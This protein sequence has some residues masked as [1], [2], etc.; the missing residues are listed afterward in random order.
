MKIL[1]EID[2]YL[3]LFLIFLYP[4]FFLP[5][6]S[7]NFDLPKLLLLVSS[8]LLI[9][10]IKIVNVLV[11]GNF[12][13]KISNLDLLVIGTALTF[14]L[15][16]IIMSPNKMDAFFSPGT[17]SFIIFASILYFFVNQLEVSGKKIATLILSL[18][19]VIFG[20]IQLLSFIGIIRINFNNFGNPIASF[21]FLL[22]I[23]SISTF[24]IFKEKM[25]SFKL[26]FGI[27]SFI[28]FISTFTSLYLLLDKTKTPLLLPSI[29]TSWSV[30]IDSIKQSPL[31]GVGPSNFLFS[32]NKFRP[33]S[34][35]LEK[36]WSTKF[37]VARNTPLTI[38][39]EVG[40]IGLGFFFSLFIFSLYRI[41]E[42]NQYNVSILLIFIISFIYPL[43]ASF[44]PIIFIL[45]ALNNKPREV[46]GI[47]NSKIPLF[48]VSLPFLGLVIATSFVTYKA[49][50]GEFLFGNTI[51]LISKNETSKIY[52]SINKT[53]TVNPYVDR[54]HQ[55]IAEID[56]AIA[57]NISKK[58]NLTDEEK[59]TLSELIQQ[60]IKDSKASIALNT[61]KSSSW[62]NLGNI[63]LD[64][65]PF[66]K[67]ADNFA[68]EAFNQAIFLDPINP[69]LRIKLGGIYYSQGK[70][71]NA[72]R[73][74]EMAVL[75]KPD[76]ASSHYNL[77]IA[78][79]ENKQIDKAKEQ[80]NIALS[81][82]N[83]DSADYE[84]VKK[85]LEK[86]ELPKE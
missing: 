73:V 82:M 41:K 67:D 27:I 66:V 9:S 51:K 55:A 23:L 52:E 13:V 30:S 14:L 45:L 77:A 57:K 10:T 36:E 83:K 70:F 19:A 11:S 39:S 7:N 31:L 69:I 63:Y 33:L 60:A 21:V 78:Y 6:F 3:T 62:E 53:V 68:I 12:K 47:F 28:I 50:Y 1:K 29:K 8:I 22:A 43:P 38:V 16:A 84:I 49:F 15:S 85:E 44:L 56:I 2:K 18:S 80:M 54:Y 59:K 17:A 86:I 4:L 40:L 46:S 48:L 37:L 71:E 42:L 75:A 58:E 25:L 34:S 32:Y 81:L 74:F 24:Q 72:S 64:I 5:F 65:S 26:F 79:K 20:I 76:L 35:N 61:S